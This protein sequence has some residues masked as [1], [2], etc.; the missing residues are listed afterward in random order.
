V[1][2]VAFSPDGKRLASVG[3]SGSIFFWDPAAAKALGDQK[4]PRGV[5]AYGVAW[6]P[7][8]KAIVVAGSDHKAHLFMLP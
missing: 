5:M 8:G 6:S 3:W 1:Y 2:A 7:D 4:L